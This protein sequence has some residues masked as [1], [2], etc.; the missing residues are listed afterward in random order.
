MYPLVNVYTTMDVITSSNGKKH[1]ILT[2]SV[3]AGG[4]VVAVV[5]FE[6]VSIVLNV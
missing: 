6:V 3:L 1:S 5:L 4:A 2:G